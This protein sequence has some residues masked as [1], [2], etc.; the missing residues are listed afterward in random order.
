MVSGSGWRRRVTAVVTIAS[1]GLL[2]STVS[3]LTFT[4]TV[5]GS[6]S[7]FHSGSP[8][9]HI[10][11]MIHLLMQGRQKD[12]ISRQSTVKAALAEA[13]VALGPKD[14]VFPDLDQ[15]L[16]D[17]MPIFACRVRTKVVARDKKIFYATSFRPAKNRWQHLP[18]IVR[19]GALGLRRKRY[20]VVYRDGR[21]TERNL[22]STTVLRPSV[23]QVIMAPH[24]YQLAS[25]GYYAGRRVF[26]MVATAY[27]PS[28][29]SC[30]PAACGKTAIGLRAGHGVVAV[31]PAMIPM[32]ARLYVEGYGYAVAGD[33]GGAIK[34]NRIDLGFRSRGQALR[35]GRRP[36]MVRVVE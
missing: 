15:P 29:Q 7:H 2:V 34:G 21:A 25:R 24:R 10:P 12:W 17:G 22:I 36:V 35:F 14:E 9:R 30:G 3:S 5:H 20:E 16:W 26:Q 11:K 27:D 1:G 28:P 6:P 19:R 31:D 18:V 32:K 13:G 4:P 8:P 33:T 23:E